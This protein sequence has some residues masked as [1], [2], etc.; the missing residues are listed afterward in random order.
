MNNKLM[1]LLT[2]ACLTLAVSGVAQ[3]EPKHEG[4]DKPNHCMKG[5]HHGKHGMGMGKGAHGKPP[6]LHGIQL[7]S[8]QDDK[9]FALTHAE[10]PKMRDHMKQ[11]HQL[12]QEL[13]ALSQAA[14]FDEGKAKQ[15]ADKLANLE[16][17][18]ALNH[19]RFDSKV[20]GLLT[21]EQREQALKNKAE[22]EKARDGH[23]PAGFHG[24][25]P[26]KHDVRS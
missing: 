19:A 2:T 5:G 9:L 4:G 13:M 23:M 8:E 14:T 25:H 24:K 11:R 26:Q 7:T 12:K 17:E 22:H 18:G 20:F 21:P 10:A 3:A 16:R 15:L 6:F 1:T